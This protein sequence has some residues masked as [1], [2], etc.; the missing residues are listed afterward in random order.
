MGIFFSVIIVLALFVLYAIN[1]SYMQLVFTLIF[2]LVVDW[3]VV[4]IFSATPL[5]GGIAIS[6]GKPILSLLIYV[7]IG[8][9][10]MGVFYNILNKYNIAISMIV[11]LLIFLI[12]NKFYMTI[13]GNILF[14]AFFNCII[15]IIIILAYQ[16][17]GVMD[18]EKWF[19]IIALAIE[20]LLSYSITGLFF[21]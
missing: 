2:Y 11:Y 21:S 1:K 12:I 10:V 5:I 14:D 20:T 19:S 3:A 15:G 16:K 7:I 8:L 17:S 6:V 9:I 4:Q 13:S 18:D